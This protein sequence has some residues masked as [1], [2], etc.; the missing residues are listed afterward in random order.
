MQVVSSSSLD[1]ATEI[2][3]PNPGSAAGSGFGARVCLECGLRFT[4]SGKEKICSDECQRARAAKRS[5]N[6]DLTY[7]NAKARERYANDPE[8]RERKKNNAR[9]AQKNRPVECERAR[10]HRR[11]QDPEYRRKRSEYAKERRKTDPHF[12]ARMR[13]NVRR[14]SKRRYANDPE[15]AAHRRQC[16][17]K[18]RA[19]RLAE[20]PSLRADK[21]LRT[22]IRNIIK[23]RGGDKSR[24]TADIIGYNP[25]LI[26]EWAA[27]NGYNPPKTHIDHIVPVSWFLSNYPLKDALRRAWQLTNLR[28][29]PAD[30]NLRKNSRREF[31]I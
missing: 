18:N 22:A 6:W 20:S 3:I 14:Y 23:K 24:K 2:G 17:R 21:N 1:S 5:R 27:N 4:P 8:Y 7:G 9:R 10:H 13:E 30:E 26:V 15:Y 28:V 31:L 19:R 11:Q 12:C 16:H 29:I 25:R